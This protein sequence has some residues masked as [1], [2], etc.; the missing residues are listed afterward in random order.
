MLNNP[1][2]IL[3]INPEIAAAPTMT[4]EDVVAAIVEKFKIVINAGT[5]KIAPPAPMVP[6][7]A[8]ITIPIK[9]ASKIITF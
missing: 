6:R 4:S 7:T 1:F 9:T 2:L 8:P 5:A 3:G